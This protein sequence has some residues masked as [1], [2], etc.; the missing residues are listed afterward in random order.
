MSLKFNMPW[1]ETL[2]CQAAGEE[3]YLLLECGSVCVAP[4]KLS[5]RLCGRTM[6]QGMGDR[7]G[8]RRTLTG[9]RLATGYKSKAHGDGFCEQLV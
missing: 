1:L 4:K 8:A 5:L 3:K 2:P 7:G 6:Q 9:N